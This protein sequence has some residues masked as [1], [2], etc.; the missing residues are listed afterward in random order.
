MSAKKVSVSQLKKLITPVEETVVDVC[1]LQVKVKPILTFADT[2]GFTSEAVRS[3]IDE[4]DENVA[5]ELYDFI[6]KSLTLKYFTNISLP[7]DI[8]EQYQLV[9][10]TQLF[11]NVV[12]AIDDKF[13]TNLIKAV[14]NKI[15][16][17]LQKIQNHI[18]VKSDL[19]ISQIKDEVQKML[20]V[21]NTIAELYQ[22]TDPDMVNTLI[23]KLVNL[24]KLDEKE[25]V[26]AVIESRSQNINSENVVR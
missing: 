26:K 12:Q 17:E 21:Y 7:N 23:P 13:Y 19:Y 2:I 4:V 25:I 18:K 9:Y 5:Y 10:E 6:I 3:I 1:G 15:Q 16:F 8:N 14:N 11:N 22:N 24:P 20:N